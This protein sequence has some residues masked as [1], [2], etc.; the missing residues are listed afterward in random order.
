MDDRI[1]LFD[2][3]GNEQEFLILASFGLDD[4]NYAALLP[5]EDLDSS[6][7]ILRME[8]DDEGNL[9]LIGIDDDEE[10]EDAINAYEEIQSENLQ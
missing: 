4:D 8:T 5:A 1:T 10:L 7:Y 2:E 9:L 6:I 3:D